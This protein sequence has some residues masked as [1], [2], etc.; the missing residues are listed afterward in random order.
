MTELSAQ[1]I[2]ETI[3]LTKTY[4][5]TTVVDKLNL[6]IEAGEIFGFLIFLPNI[7]YGKFLESK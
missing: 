5:G 6:R 7:G 2:I 4:E 3:D 1:P